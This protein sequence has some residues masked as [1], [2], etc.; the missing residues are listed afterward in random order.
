MNTTSGIYRILNLVNNKK[1]F[2]QTVDFNTRWGNHY[3]QLKGM[4]HFNPHLQTSWNK[5]GPDVFIFQIMEYCHKE[6]LDEREQK[7]LD[8]WFDG[9]VQ[10]YNILPVASSSRNRTYSEESKLKMSASAKK[11]QP[12][13]SRKG[14]KHSEEYKKRLSKIMTGRV[15][16]VEHNKKLADSKRGKPFT[17]EH[18]ANLCKTII[19]VEL[20]NNNFERQFLGLKAARDYY[21]V[22]VPVIVRC[23]NNENKIIKNGTLK[24]KK[25]VI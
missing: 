7:Y 3:N 8:E 15:R 25:S 18:V 9:G 23:L 16:T 12:P 17:K 5:H 22:S 19:A 10:C 21:K 1:Y 6:Q 20:L 2:G 13:P 14:I 4:R 24:F 11:R